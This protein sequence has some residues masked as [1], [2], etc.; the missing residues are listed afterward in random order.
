MSLNDGFRNTS[1]KLTG[2]QQKSRQ[3]LCTPTKQKKSNQ[4]AQKQKRSFVE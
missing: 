4:E 3:H 1:T 2:E